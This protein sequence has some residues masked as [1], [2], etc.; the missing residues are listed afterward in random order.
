MIIHDDE[1]TA[2]VAEPDSITV[3]QYEFLI[4]E[5]QDTENEKPEIRDSI[6]N[7]FGGQYSMD[8]TYYGR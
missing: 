5:K 6:V 4:D 3:E 2:T 1:V 7:V 8:V